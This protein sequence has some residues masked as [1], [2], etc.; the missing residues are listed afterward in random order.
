V[1]I[2]EEGPDARQRLERMGTLAA[3]SLL[4]QIEREEDRLLKMAP[5]RVVLDSPIATL[6]RVGN[7]PPNSP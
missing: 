4:E 1:E 5:G 7:A 2:Q 3:R 6:E